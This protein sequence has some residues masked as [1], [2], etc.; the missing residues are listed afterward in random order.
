MLHRLN[1]ESQG[2]GTVF[3]AR[4]ETN[5]QRDSMHLIP[6]KMEADSPLKTAAHSM[7]GRSESSTA[8]LGLLES[9]HCNE[10]NGNSTDKHDA[11]VLTTS[12]MR[13]HSC[14]ASSI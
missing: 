3:Y 4:A 8:S 12:R 13:V 2:P 14:G 11:T 6:R 1:N 10:P 5:D 7:S 9:V